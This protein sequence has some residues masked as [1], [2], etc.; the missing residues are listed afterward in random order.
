MEKSEF[1]KLLKLKIS[2]L[3]W[4]Q[5]FQK[6]ATLQTVVVFLEH[7]IKTES[8]ETM[9]RET[10]ISGRSFYN[11]LFLSI[12]LAY[13]GDY[14]SALLLLKKAKPDAKNQKIGN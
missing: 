13:M 4:E 1:L 3:P 12:G 11:E 9:I 2:E 5:N 10:C 7:G 14:T 6:F 8:V